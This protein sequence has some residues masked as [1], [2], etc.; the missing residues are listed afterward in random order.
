MKRITLA[1]YNPR[2]GTL[3]DVQHPEDYLK[4]PTPNSTNIYIDKLL[5]EHNKYLKKGQKYYIIC[6]KGFLSKKA[7]SMLEYFGYDVTQVIH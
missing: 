7:V 2:L 6:N 3:I 4:N 5:L 1:N